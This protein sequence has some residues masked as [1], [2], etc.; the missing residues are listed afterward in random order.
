MLLIEM[1]LTWP[2]DAPD[3]VAL[4]LLKHLQQ[5]DVPGYEDYGNIPSRSPEEDLPGNL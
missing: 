5:Q 3:P 2:Q 4:N 1:L